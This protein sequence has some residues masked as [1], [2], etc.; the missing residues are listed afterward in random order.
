M[1][2]ASKPSDRI[3]L[4]PPSVP[5][6]GVANPAT[7]LPLLHA[8]DF[9]SDQEVR[10]CPGCGDFSILAAFKKVLA[11]CGVPRERIVVVSGLGCSSRMPFYL[12]TYGFQTILG[13]APAIAT[14]LK[15]AQPDLQVWVIT[16]D[17]DGLSAGL[18]HLLHALRRNVDIKILLVDNETFGQSRGQF[19]PTSRPGT[20]SRSSPLGSN[21]E[22]M[23]PI[24]LALASEASFVARGIDVDVD[25]L[26]R[27]LTRAA[28][29][30]GSA[31]VQI[32][33]NCKVFNDGVFEY[34]TEH[35]DKDDSLIYLEQGQPLIFGKDRNRGLALDGLQL[36]EVDANQN[37]DRVLIHDETAPQATLAGMLGRLRFP[38]FPECVGVFRAV[39]R[40]CHHEMIA[41]LREDARR[42][43]GAPPDLQ[44][45]LTGEETW[46]VE[47]LG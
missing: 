2:H 9:S 35:A 46:T 24:P 13:R 27:I 18:N 1:T 43:M 12:N 37:P 14:G 44:H 41:E 6:A 10:W 16:G 22:P 30:R 42:Q 20:R 32:Y 47:G 8:K 28:N 38:D 45:L 25:H 15:L 31:F 17:G 3:P 7:T 29:H 19:S 11:G 26:T 39:E 5:G 40:P 33:Q 23:L 34:A 4:V 36:V 21:E